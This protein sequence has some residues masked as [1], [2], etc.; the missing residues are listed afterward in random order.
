MKKSNNQIKYRIKHL[1]G[2]SFLIRKARDGFMM[3]IM[4]LISVT[5]HSQVHK[6]AFEYIYQ[7]IKEKNFFKAKD[8]Y[9]GAK[10]NLTAEYQYFVEAILDNAFNKTEL[11]NQKIQKIEKC[12]P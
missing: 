8:L 11:S 5:C 3:F 7:E 2:R 6:S 9:N 10:G 12:H 4:I 1:I